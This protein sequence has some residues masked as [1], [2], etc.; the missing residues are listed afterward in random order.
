VTVRLATPDDVDA[1]HALIDELAHYERSAHEFVA[2]V[3]Q[4]R[5]ALFADA[6]HV[7][8]H[9]AEVDGEV[10]G[11]ALWFL[12]YS[13][14]LGTSG[15]YLEDLYVKPSQRGRGLGMALMRALA[16]ICL[17]RGYTRFSWSVLDW[18][19]P[20]IDFYR[21]IGAV[22][23]DEWTTYRLEGGALRDYA[24]GG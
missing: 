16:T 10:V 7:F 22:A 21:S 2:T 17:E 18:N 24:D 19:T 9:L 15:I 23:M 12:N 13:T 20:S 3:D 4:L 8:C 11:L 1:I 6:P 5:A 14:W